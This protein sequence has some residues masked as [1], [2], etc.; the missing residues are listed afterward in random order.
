MFLYGKNSVFTRLRANPRSIRRILVRENFDISSIKEKAQ[1]YKIPIVRVSSKKLSKI[2]PGK[3]LQGIVAGVKPF[4]YTPIESL[5]S[6]PQKNLSF[7]FLDE[8]YD[9]QN[10]GAIIRTA[11]CLGNFAIVIPRHRACGVTET[12]LHIASGG[13]NFVPISLV[14]NLSNTLKEVKKKGYWIIGAIPQGD[15]DVTTTRF[16]FPVGVVLGSEQGNVRYG[17]RK[18]IDLAAAIPMEGEALSLNVAVACAIFCYEVVKQRR[19]FSG[20][21]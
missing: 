18:Q 2:K 10:L 4:E 9:P 6:S 1:L 5:L 3:N 8:V 19:G 15:R 14:S 16:P 21:N 17:V 12:V 20:N 7:I 13:E 11:A